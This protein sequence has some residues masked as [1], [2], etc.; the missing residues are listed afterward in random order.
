MTDEQLLT[1]LRS[2]GIFGVEDRKIGPY[3][4]FADN[5][6]KAQSPEPV[7]CLRCGFVTHVKDGETPAET[8]HKAYLQRTAHW[9]NLT[10]ATTIREGGGS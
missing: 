5:I 8:T 4:R 7:T 6:L 2:A 3:R 9:M 1:A 10:G